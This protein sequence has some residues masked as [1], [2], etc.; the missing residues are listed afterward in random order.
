MAKARKVWRVGCGAGTR[1]NYLVRLPAAG[2]TGAA[3]GDGEVSVETAVG[4]RGRARNCS[5]KKEI[6]RK[7]AARDKHAVNVNSFRPVSAHDCL[8]DHGGRYRCIGS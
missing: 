5:V 1:E 4:T 7:R 6:R 2:T 3:F 8:L